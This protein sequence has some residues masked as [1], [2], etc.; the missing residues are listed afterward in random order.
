MFT[1]NRYWISLAI[2]TVICLLI[3]AGCSALPTTANGGTGYGASAG[4][5]PEKPAIPP[6]DI[7]PSASLACL[8]CGTAADE[9][10]L[11][12]AITKVELRYVDA[13]KIEKWYTV[14]DSKALKN[15]LPPLPLKIGASGAMALI[16]FAQV[17]LQSYTALRIS[18]D[19]KATTFTKKDSATP[20]TLETDTFDLADWTLDTK[21]TNNI[22]LTLDGSKVMP[23]IDSAPAKLT[24]A[25]ISV[26][27]GTALGS[28]SG[29]LTP[30]VG[31]AKVEAYWGESK[32]AMASATANSEDGSFTVYNLPPGSYRL[33]IIAAGHRPTTALKPTKVETTNTDLGAIALSVDGH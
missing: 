7:P 19:S 23:A 25:A 30:A 33:N 11:T 16:S 28:V 18:V 8:V 10:S 20:L 26:A 29:K 21:I 13:K 24:A 9:T 2:V 22:I 3:L 27:K 6:T 31:N 4:L 15:A 12:L 17:P 14:A 32:V 5:L 1:I